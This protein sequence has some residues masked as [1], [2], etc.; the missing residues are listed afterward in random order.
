LKRDKERGLTRV[1]ATEYF[2][3]AGTIPYS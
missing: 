2:I 3:F 1:K